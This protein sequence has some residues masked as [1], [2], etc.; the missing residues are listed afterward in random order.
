MPALN[1]RK[2]FAG[3]VASGSKRQTIRKLRKDGR[4]P[5]PGQTLYLFTQQR[6][7]KCQRLGE[8]ICTESTS[9]IIDYGKV[10]L[11]CMPLVE[12]ETLALAIADGFQT[13]KEFQDFFDKYYGF[14]FYG[15]LIKW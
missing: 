3:M 8:A 1:F 9:I 7:T 2:E 13:R 15:L 5:K 11:D 10:Y 6:T 14:P 12:F 4:D